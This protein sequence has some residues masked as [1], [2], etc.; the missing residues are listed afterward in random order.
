MKRKQHS[1]SS[2]LRKSLSS[3]LT[4]IQSHFHCLCEEIKTFVLQRLASVKESEKSVDTNSHKKLLQLLLGAIPYLTTVNDEN[5]GTQIFVSLA[6][7]DVEAALSLHRFC[8]GVWTQALFLEFQSKVQKG[9][10]KREWATLCEEA[11]LEANWWIL[12]QLKNPT[13]SLVAR[14]Y[15]VCLAQ[16]WLLMCER[17]ESQ[18]AA[19]GIIP[20]M[21]GGLVVNNDGQLQTKH[22]KHILHL[23]IY[24]RDVQIAFHDALK[25]KTVLLQSVQLTK[26][27]RDL[28]RLSLILRLPELLVWIPTE[29][30]TIIRGYCS[31]P[32]QN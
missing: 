11:Q 23:Y 13:L 31:F 14:L 24:G 12:Y 27:Q 32:E 1:E 6:K 16:C 8:E 2:L 4:D 10:W 25:N 28:S 18:T 3:T 21:E 9:V 20:K 26:I 15:D 30:C 5:L 29:V 17:Y 7:L 19:L 22:A